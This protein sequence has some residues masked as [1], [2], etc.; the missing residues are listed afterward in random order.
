[1]KRILIVDTSQTF[2][3]NYVMV[4]LMDDNGVPCGGWLGYLKSLRFMIEKIQPTHVINVFDGTGGSQKRKDIAHEYKEGRKP[5]K[6]NRNMEY[7]ESLDV[8]ENRRY[9][10]SRLVQ[11]LEHLPVYNV[12]VDHVEADDVIAYLCSHF[13]DDEKVIASTDKDF[14]QLLDKKTIVWNTVKKEFVTSKHVF[15]EYQIHPNNFAIARALVGDS[16]DNLKGISGVGF[17]TVLK[18]I[19][20]LQDEHELS[21]HEL[22]NTWN[23]N[24]SEIVSGNVSKENKKLF[25]KH[26]LFVNN[27]ELIERNYKLM[28]L[29]ETVMSPQSITKIK[30]SLKSELN[31]NKTS[32]T[33]NLLKDGIKSIGPTFFIEFDKLIENKEKLF[34][35]SNQQV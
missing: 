22:F 5:L 25:E 17:K 9:Q 24:A 1:M 11:Y 7:D 6:L 23:Q 13:K 2:I 34:N 35:D 10:W 8:N 4:P 26:S 16:S 28:Q 14:F 33:V 29:R 27:R 18:Y 19:P 21:L 20:A 12:N 30:H 15:E 31:L 3:R 32:F